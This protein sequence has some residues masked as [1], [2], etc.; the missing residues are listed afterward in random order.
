VATVP[1]L[2][3]AAAAAAAADTMSIGLVTMMMA[4]M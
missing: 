2:Q 4:K 1:V 3:A